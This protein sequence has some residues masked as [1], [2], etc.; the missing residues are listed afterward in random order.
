MTRHLQTFAFV[1]VFAL[2]SG[3]LVRAQEKPAAAPAAKAPVTALKVQVVISRFQAEKRIS[4]LPY[5]LSVNA[6]DNSEARLRMG[7]QVPVPT[8]AAPTVDGKPVAGL[9]KAGPIQYKDVGTNIDCVANSVDD[10][11]FRL[12]ISVEDFS[13]YGDFEGAQGASKT[14]DNPSFR[15]FRS[16]NTLVLKDGQSTQFTT[17]TD[18]ITGETVKVDVTLSV[19]K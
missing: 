9:V 16:T 12:F 13:V 11:R 19:A 15:S 3:P 10:G 14:G 2:T 7:A 8:M 1:V 18:R 6:N 5:M 17:A 4:S